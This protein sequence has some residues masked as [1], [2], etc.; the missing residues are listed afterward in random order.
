MTDERPPKPKDVDLV[1]GKDDLDAIG[2][3]RA[4]TPTVHELAAACGTKVREEINPHTGRKELVATGPI[5]MVA[6]AMAPSWRI[7]SD[8]EVRTVSP[9]VFENFGATRRQGL[10]ASLRWRPFDALTLTTSWGVARTEILKNANAALVGR[11]VAGVPA[12]AASVDVEYA[13]L[14]AWSFTAGWRYVGRY[15]LDAANSQTAESYA[16]LGLGLA[17]VGEGRWPY[18]AYLRIENA[19]DEPHATNELLLAG[20][21]AVAPGAPRSVRAGLQFGFR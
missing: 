13:P 10:D 8:G 1:M 14:P 18:R 9:G 5:Q 21:R 11:R 2:K 12:G 7:E 4:V 3:A 16:L 20:Q 6:E 19:G 15:D 17:Y